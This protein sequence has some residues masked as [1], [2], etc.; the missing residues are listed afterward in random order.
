MVE[1]GSEEEKKILDAPAKG[2]FALL[3]LVFIIYVI[4]WAVMFFGMFLEHGPVN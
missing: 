2:T 1:P 3:M 4:A